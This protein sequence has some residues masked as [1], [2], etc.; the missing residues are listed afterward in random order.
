[1]RNLEMQITSRV[2]S[3]VE[4]LIGIFVIFGGLSLVFGISAVLSKLIG[5][6]VLTIIGVIFLVALSAVTIYDTLWHIAR[7]IDKYDIK[8]NIEV[9]SKEA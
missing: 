5:F 6:W 2:R 8:L 9:S 3:L 7:I 1:M 4:D